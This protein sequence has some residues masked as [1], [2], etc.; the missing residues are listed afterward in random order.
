MSNKVS[1]ANQKIMRE[2]YCP[3]CGYCINENEPLTKVT[4]TP[5]LGDFAICVRCSGVAQFDASASVA[6]KR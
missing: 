1:R 5:E 4:R 2:D 6:F 3:H